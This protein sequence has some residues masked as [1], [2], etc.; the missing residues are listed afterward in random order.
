MGFPRGER[1]ASLERIEH[2][3]CHRLTGILILQWS[4]RLAEC[5]L[6]GILQVA[7]VCG[8]VAE[9]ADGKCLVI[10]EGFGGTLQT[11]TVKVRNMP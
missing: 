10:V 3:E 2:L 5:Y 9:V 8:P 4:E 7:V 11:Q 1:N 6:Y